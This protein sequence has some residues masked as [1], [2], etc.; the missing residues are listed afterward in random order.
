MRDVR[1]TAVLAAIEEL[2]RDEPKPKWWEAP[3]R[4]FGRGAR[5]EVAPPPLELL[6][7]VAG[8]GV[9]PDAQVTRYDSPY[10]GDRMPSFRTLAPPAPEE[11]GDRRMRE[12]SER[13]HRLS[14]K[15]REHIYGEIEVV[16]LPR[17]Y[18]ALQAVFGMCVHHLPIRGGYV[19]YRYGGDFGGLAKAMST[20]WTLERANGEPWIVAARDLLRD[21]VSANSTF[22]EP[23]RFSVRDNSVTAPLNPP[24]TFSELN[25]IRVLDLPTCGDVF[26]GYSMILPLITDMERQLQRQRDSY[27]S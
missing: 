27:P 17:E 13:V 24:R 9:F 10:R 26:V 19:A 8:H 6:R 5:M 15:L 2:E 18:P 1:E 22:F 12:W 23:V 25:G 14:M 4:A 3:E 20:Y 11:D 16:L 7:E 21:A